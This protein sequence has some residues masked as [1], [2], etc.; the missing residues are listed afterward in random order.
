MNPIL[1]SAIEYARLGL[2]VHFQKGKAA[3][4]L[5]WSSGPPKTEEQLKRDYREGCNIGFMTG[6]RSRIGGAPIVVLDPDL[7][8]ADPRHAE[9][10]NAVVRELVSGTEPTVRT[11]S[12]SSHFYFKMNGE[13]LPPNSLVLRQSKDMVEWREDGKTKSLPAW[14]IEYLVDHA[15]T[16][17]PSL[18]PD[19]GE[20]YAWVNGGLSKIGPPPE[21]LLKAIRDAV[22]SPRPREWGPRGNL[23]A[24]ELPPVLAFHPRLLPDPIRPWIEDEAARM[25]CP[26]DFVAVTV[27]VVISSVIGAICTIHP[28]GLDPWA[29]AAILWGMLVGPPG[30]MKTP[31]MT[32]GA[33]PLTVLVAEA[34][35][36]YK[37]QMLAYAVEKRRYD[38]LMSALEEE[39][40]KAA[41][42]NGDRDTATSRVTER[43]RDLESRAPKEPVQRRY[44]T[45]DATVEKVV[46]LLCDNPR[47]VMHRLDELTRLLFGFERPEH[48]GDRGAY[49]EGYEALHSKAIDR[50]KRGERFASNN[51]ITLLGG[52]QPDALGAWLDLTTDISKNDGI[53]QR[54][55]LMVYPGATSWSWVDRAPKPGAYDRAVLIF[56][57]LAD[58]DPMTW[59]AVQGE[60]DKFPWFQF[61]PDAQKVF[62]QW[63]TELR[64][65]RHREEDDPLIRQHLAKYDRVFCSLSLVFHLIERA[66]YEIRNP[67]GVDQEGRVRYDSGFVGN[68][69][70]E[71]CARRAAAWVEYLESHMRR[72]YALL[73]HHRVRNAGMLAARIAR[74]DLKEGFTK[75]DIIRRQWTGLKSDE[76]VRTALDWLESERW[77]RRAQRVAG[78]GGRPTDRYEIHPEIIAGQKQ[79]SNA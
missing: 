68:E 49:L 63:L 57:R 6:I 1:E 19:S 38:A 4:E 33:K 47:G 44:E 22:T 78:Q 29:V 40:K 12:G 77:I 8:S 50:I 52:I 42:V 28:K 16:L 56:K 9:E 73:G 36:K 58:F 27:I 26:I 65:V 17:P 46:D 54:F 75:R 79:N 45:H 10:M 30:D 66:D 7:R 25:P 24:A 67:G 53:Q 3:F 35:Q 59:G 76:E 41:R 51:C 13:S 39:L 14:R 2:A 60:H 62:I 20:A 21:T 37:E 64:N 48:A 18:H 55:G 5:G 71:K 69:V 31:A 72:C 43:I 74:G 23:G 11:G 32:A 15:C 70:S 34:R 61:S